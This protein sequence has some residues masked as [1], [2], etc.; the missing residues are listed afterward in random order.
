MW[1]ATVM[2]HHPRATV[3]LDAA[4]ASRLQL[5]DYYREVFANKPAWQGL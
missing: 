5:G 4:A 2:Q 3:L 1:P